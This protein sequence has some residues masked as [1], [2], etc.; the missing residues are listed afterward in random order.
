M[1]NFVSRTVGVLLLL[2]FFGIQLVSAQ[3]NKKQALAHYANDAFGDYIQ[4]INAQQV[5]PSTMKGFMIWL[6][7]ASISVATKSN[8]REYLS[9]GRNLRADK[10]KVFQVT[11]ASYL[12][13]GKK[14]SAYMIFVHI[15]AQKAFPVQADV[16]KV[17]ETLKASADDDC[18]FQKGK[19][20]F[21]ANEDN[22]DCVSCTGCGCGGCASSGGSSLHD[23]ILETVIW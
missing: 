1:I 9:H 7:N 16:I 10:I 13:S 4:P 19:E 21:C 5:S 15:S 2:S 6:E 11:N 23:N 12:S 20:Y 3:A 18:T 8:I 17:F 22:C 14:G